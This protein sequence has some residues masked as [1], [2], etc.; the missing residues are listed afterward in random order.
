MRE[1]SQNAPPAAAERRVYVRVP[2]LRP[3]TVS[4]PPDGR[5][6]EARTLDISLGG[7]GLTCSVPFRKGQVVVVTFHLQDPKLGAVVERVEGRVANFQ[8][9]PDA[10]R[11]GIEFLEP[12]HSA[13]NPALTRAVGRL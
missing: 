12:L 11:V 7:V 10:N 4:A 13:A 5:P 1:P 8:A 9:D 6:A 2:F 3:V